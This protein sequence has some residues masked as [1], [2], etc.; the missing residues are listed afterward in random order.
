VISFNEEERLTPTIIRRRIA[1]VK[2]ALGQ[3]KEST[4]SLQ[5]QHKKDLGISDL[6]G[7][8]LATSERIDTSLERQL[9]RLSDAEKVIKRKQSQ[10]IIS[11]HAV[12]R[13]I[14]RVLKINTSQIRDRLKGKDINKI[15][16]T[17]SGS[18][19]RD[20]YTLIIANGVVTTI[21]ADGM[22]DLNP[23]TQ[24]VR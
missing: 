21:L 10:E 14:E 23:I 20:D 9:V 18:I 8:N 17:V 24:E 3:N 22:I 2:R 7:L 5:L 4:E 16:D 13:Y 11:D 6:S 12:L 19:D 1:T 15:K